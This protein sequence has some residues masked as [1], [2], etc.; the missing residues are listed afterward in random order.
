MADYFVDRDTRGLGVA[1]VA[2][3][4]GRCPLRDD[5]LV[6]PVIQRFGSDARLDKRR[7]EVERLRGEL[8]RAMQSY[9]VLFIVK[10]HL[11]AIYIKRK[12]ARF[13]VGR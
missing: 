10:R 13:G 7:N 11:P 9:K 8:A 5:E 3:R 4:C 12:G 6:H 1:F 2:Q